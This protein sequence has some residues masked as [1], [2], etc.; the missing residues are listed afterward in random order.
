MKSYLL[1]GL[2]VMLTLV[3]LTGCDANGAAE[4]QVVNLY[5]DRH[6][7]T[8]D[9]L[10]ARFT[11]ETGIT[12]NVIKGKSDELI[13]RLKREGEST[14]A[15]LFITADAG[16]LHRAKEENLLTAV[17]NEQ[18]LANVPENLRDSDNQWIGLTKRARVLIYAKDRVT[19][20]ELSTY[21][22]LTDPRWE[23]RILVRSSENIYN[24]S[25]LASMIAL[26]GEEAARE[27]A[28]GLVANFARAPQGNDR[29]QAKAVV[30]GEG[31]VA[32]MNTYYLGKMLNSSDPEEVRVA[33]SVGL[34]FPNQETTGTHVNVSGA[35]IVRAAKHPEA[36]EALL[37]YLTS[38]KAQ[39]DYASA[40]YEYPVN[41][42]VAPSELL[43]SWGT[44]KAQDLPLSELGEQ[45]GIAIRLF[46]EAGWQ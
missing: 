42:E 29:D 43:R 22:D 14:Q 5:T 35:G 3:A 25:L 20:E 44:F 16:R 11:E 26:E 10:Y 24:Q 6:Y 33:E 19:E 4:E 31:D 37:L 7:D 17:T 39:S 9:A 2:V 32:I 8:D 28:E 18:T 40:N 38:E 27:W 34:F 1:W 12:V 23:G 15:D 30:A 45:N 46:D 13:E 41:P 36:A 21:A